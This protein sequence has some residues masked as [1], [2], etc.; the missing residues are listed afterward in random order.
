MIAI[1]DLY[2][3]VFLDDDRQSLIFN[4]ETSAKKYIEKSFVL[5]EG[6]EF[7]IIEVKGTKVVFK[8]KTE[9]EL[10][11]TSEYFSLTNK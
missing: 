11:S 5:R 8:I 1:F 7:L 3:K 9:L 10:A 6:G 2:D 4:D